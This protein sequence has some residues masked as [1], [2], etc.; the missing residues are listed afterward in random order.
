MLAECQRIESD[1]GEARARLGALAPAGIAKLAA[2]VEGLAALLDAQSD[3]GM[4]TRADAERDIETARR[5]MKETESA[6]EAAQRKFGKER[7]HAA[8]RGATAADRIKRLSELERRLPAPAARMGEAEGLQARVAQCETALNDAVRVLAAWRE[9]AP[10]LMQLQKLESEAAR[11]AEALR[12]AERA[13]E[14]LRRSI[15]SLEG[16]LRA[17]R[18]EDVEARV[19]ELKG[20][21][22]TAELRADRMADEVAA[23]KLLDEE[24]AR[25]EMR[26]RDLYLRPVT[27]RLAGV[28]G[29]VFPGADVTVAENFSPASLRRSNDREAIAALSEGTQEQL[30]VMV[31]LAFGRLMA[32]SGTPVPVILDDALVYSDDERI[33]RMFA[34]LSAAGEHH[35]LIVLTCR[36]RTF[37]SLA[38][39]RL[40]VVAWQADA[41][42]APRAAAGGR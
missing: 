24:L 20:A 1:L 22:E 28:V 36:S 17:D 33:L 13:R 30:A 4:V 26:S 5:V 14:E 6:D 34:A 27:E 19:A 10:E 8:Q 12:G 29:L 16:E 2:E 7:E 21:L 41:T 15:A 37:E 35:Q 25:E 31:R 3:A 23:L 9:Q 32:D 42:E 39:H 18:N 40:A 38:G 11:A